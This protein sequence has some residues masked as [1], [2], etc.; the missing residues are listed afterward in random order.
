MHNTSASNVIRLRENPKIF[1]KINVD[2]IEIGTVRNGIIVLFIFLRKIR[3][4][5]VTNMIAK[6]RVK[7]TSFRASDTKSEVS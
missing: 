2:K 3:I 7:I 6:H 5:K 1:K 4:I